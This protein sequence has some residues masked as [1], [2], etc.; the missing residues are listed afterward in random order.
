MQPDGS[1]VACDVTAI[2]THALRSK[3]V[4]MDTKLNG[5]PVMK[6][7]DEALFLEDAL[8]HYQV[9]EEDV[10][11]IGYLPVPTGAADWTSVATT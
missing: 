4:R 11:E 3:G 8:R 5:S 7:R 2:E 10:E 6:G 9:L 1:R